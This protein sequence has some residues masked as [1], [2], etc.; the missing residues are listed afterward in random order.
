MGDAA[1][2]VL[3][4]DRPVALGAAERELKH[5]LDLIDDAFGLLDM[6]IDRFE[7]VGALR[8]HLAARGRLGL[9]FGRGLLGDLK[10]E[11]DRRVLQD[12][13]VALLDARLKHDALIGELPH[14]RDQ[15]F[16]GIHAVGH[17]HLDALEVP[18]V[19]FAKGVDHMAARV[20]ECA[21]A[22][23]D[24][25]LKADRLGEVGIGVQRVP[26]AAEAIEQRL[27]GGHFLFDARVGRAVWRLDRRCGLAAIAAPAARAAHHDDQVVLD[28]RFAVLGVADR[29]DVDDGVF[30]LVQD[31]LDVRFVGQRGLGGKRS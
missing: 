9:G 29:L 30:A 17:A 23:Q 19:T 27:V 1:G 18:R 14:I 5:R 4:I 2:R 21:K 13:R 10:V 6:L 26:V 7:D 11:L 31:L 28:Q 16:A 12:D 8:N 24:R 25:A 20:P 3:E 15:R 22:V